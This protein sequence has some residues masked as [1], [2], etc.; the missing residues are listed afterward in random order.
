MPKEIKEMKHREL[1]SFMNKCDKRIV[2]L[3][4]ELRALDKK[5]E[6]LKAQVDNFKADRKK[7]FNRV[8]ELEG[9]MVVESKEATE[10][11]KVVTEQKQTEVAVNNKKAVTEQK[12]VATTQTQNNKGEIHFGEE[13]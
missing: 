6:K 1:L 13:G 7:A 8:A 12:Q 5:T 9:V 11:K 3:E 2:K 10:S 4:T